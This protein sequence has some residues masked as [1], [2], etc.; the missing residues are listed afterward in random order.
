M[1]EAPAERQRGRTMSISSPLGV[2]GP[3]TV[4]TAL[5]PVR[6]EE[7]PGPPGHI[8]RQ[9]LVAV[10]L[11][12]PVIVLSA[13]PALH[14]PHW[15][16]AALALACVVAGWGRAMLQHDAARSRADLLVAAAVLA[17]LVWS[18][19]GLMAGVAP[20]YPEVAAAL[21]VYGLTARLTAAEAGA[22]R[23]DGLGTR[24]AIAGTVAAVAALGFWFGSGGPV[25]AFTATV[26]V[27]VA[28]CPAA[29]A[30]TAPTTVARAARVDTV[31]L[32]ESAVVDA[33]GLR[34]HAVHPARGAG[35]ADALRLAGAIG[36]AAERP[37]GRAIAAA[38]TVAT[39]PLPGVAEFDEVPGLGWR[40]IVAEVMRRGK[41]HTVIAHAVL[42]GSAELLTEHGIT[43]PAELVAAAA[44]AGATGRTAVAVAWDGVPRAVLVIGAAARP[45][46][47]DAVRRLRALR[48]APVL[49]VEPGSAT[50]Y[51]AAG[52]V[53][54]R[55]EEL[56]TGR[57]AVERLRGEGRVV[58]VVGEDPET[59]P[60]DAPA[61][62]EALHL[63]R[64]TAAVIR[65]NAM[66]AVGTTAA[67]VPFA[68]AGVMDPTLA[69]AVV[70]TSSAVVLA[71]S[72][73]LHRARAGED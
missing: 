35:G 24:V 38:A 22:L 25:P 9:L 46:A 60:A 7:E 26:A 64:R 17:A 12:A 3:M 52:Q 43:L 4:G 23:P 50:A 34:V 68:V 27:L 11:T 70:V 16:W 48:L 66:L 65:L 73:R 42:A 21:T 55:P 72:L 33:D 19:A 2:V 57:Q 69:A 47:A 62:V 56:A 5:L 49:L 53:G 31:V 54:L 30:M 67:T 71:N 13:V 32:P 59:A 58:A 14:F 45:G 6:R 41:D 44:N 10:G 37:V 20:V 51:A 36:R 1:R 18:L 40:G 15:Q 39:G 29:L 61:A 28:A 63:A 8:R